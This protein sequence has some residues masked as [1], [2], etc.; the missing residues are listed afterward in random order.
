MRNMSKLNDK[1]V[2]WRKGM[3]DRIAEAANLIIS[4]TA[5]IQVSPER[6]RSSTSWRE[7]L[8]GVRVRL[9]LAS[10]VKTSNNAAVCRKHSQSGCCFLFANRRVTNWRGHQLTWAA[11]NQLMA[12]SPGLETQTRQQNS[13]VQPTMKWTASGLL[14]SQTSKQNSRAQQSTHICHL[15]SKIQFFS[16]SS[17]PLIPLTALENLYRRRHTASQKNA[18]CHFF[19]HICQRS[20]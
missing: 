4:L 1:R 7:T 19:C 18:G 20:G 6:F 10:K 17:K 15:Q 3:F 12:F 16:V 14:A 5:T 11:F 2:P 8:Q 9:P 13:H